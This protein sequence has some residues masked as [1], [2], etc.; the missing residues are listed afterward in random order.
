VLIQQSL[1]PA[2]RLELLPKSTIDVFLVVIENDGIEGCVAAGSIAASTALA[3]AGI[4]MLGLVVACSA[5]SLLFPYNNVYA[6]SI[7]S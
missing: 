4:E 5:V 2:V 7:Y 1:T 6:V 3:H